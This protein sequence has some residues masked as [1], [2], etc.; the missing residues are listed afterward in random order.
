MDSNP[1]HS[2]VLL[3]ELPSVEF[4]PTT[5]CS[6]GERALYQL[7]LWCQFRKTSVGTK[8]YSKLCLALQ[9]ALADY[10]SALSSLS[11]PPSP[12]SLPPS[13]LLL[14]LLVNRGL[15]C[16]E[17]GD[18]TTAI[19]DLSLAQQVSPSLFTHISHIVRRGNASLQL[20]D[21]QEQ[22]DSVLTRIPTALYF[23][24]SVILLV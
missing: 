20:Y 15:L 22:A 11:L 6:L 3:K 2:A 10:S 7:I 18:M 23:Q 16:L 1:R 5:L 4:E 8:C 13:P 19:H 21:T 14:P 17:R 24:F 12:L 9:Q